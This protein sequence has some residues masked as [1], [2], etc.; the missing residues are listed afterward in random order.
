MGRGIGTGDSIVRSFSVIDG[1]NFILEQDIS[2]CISRNGG[3]FTSK[4]DDPPRLF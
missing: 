4:H 1:M 2:A 3:T